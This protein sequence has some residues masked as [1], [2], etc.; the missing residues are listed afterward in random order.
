MVSD[1]SASPERVSNPFCPAV[2][3]VRERVVHVDRAVA[4]TRSSTATASEEVTL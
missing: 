3:T 4:G 1:E 2:R